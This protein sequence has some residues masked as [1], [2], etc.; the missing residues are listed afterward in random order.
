MGSPNGWAP[1]GSHVG[2]LDQPDVDAPVG[3][4]LGVGR[5]A[6]QVRLDGGSEPVG[7][8]APGD[9]E[10]AAQDGVRERELLG[11]DLHAPA[12]RQRVRDRREAV[13]VQRQVREIH[14]QPGVRREV[15]RER[16][17]LLDHPVGDRGIGDALPEQI[18]ADGVPPRDSRSTAASAS[19][20]DRPAT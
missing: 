11:A 6:Q 4:R 18:E 1:P 9:G 10:D 13:G 8:A 14:R 16:A 7:Q 2:A 17:V 5:R 20:R 12:G 15:G 19:L 3:E